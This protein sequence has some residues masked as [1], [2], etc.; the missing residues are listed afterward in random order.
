MKAVNV[1]F[2]VKK[3]F[4]DVYEVKKGRKILARVEK[5]HG[6]NEWAWALFPSGKSSIYWYRPTMEAAFDAVRGALSDYLYGLCGERFLITSD[7]AICR[8]P[9]PVD[10]IIGEKEINIKW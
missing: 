6:L 10:L 3:R 9:S 7:N 5:R 1:K 8:I 4:D 2:S